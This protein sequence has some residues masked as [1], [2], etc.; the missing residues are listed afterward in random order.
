MDDAGVYR[1][2]EDIALILTLDFFTP[3][4]DDPRI[5]GQIAAA[6]ALSDVYAMGGTPLIALNIVCFPAEEKEL[7]AE[8]LLGGAEKIKEAGALL[9]GGH[10][11][12]DQEPKYGLSVTGI[13]HPDRVI[14]NATLETGIRE[15]L[16]K[17]FISWMLERFKHKL[18]EEVL[19][20]LN[21]LTHWKRPSLVNSYF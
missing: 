3:I 7:L 19:A 4:V 14:T 16:Q 17:V 8:V 2:S 13:V 12:E 6:N 21:I 20:M 15:R 5:F 18:Y 11:V 1:L 9:V 10:S